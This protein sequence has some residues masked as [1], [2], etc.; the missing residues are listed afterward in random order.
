MRHEFESHS[1]FCDFQ[2]LFF[3]FSP[4]K[5][6]EHAFFY[7][8]HKNY[9]DQSIEQAL[10]E[11]WFDMAKQYLC[12]VRLSEQAKP[13][14]K[15]AEKVSIDMNH[16]ILF[17]KEEEGQHLFSNEEKFL[18]HHKRIYQ[19]C[20]NEGNYYIEVDDDVERLG[21]RFIDMIEVLGRCDI[22]EVTNLCLGLYEKLDEKRIREYLLHIKDM[23]NDQGFPKRCAANFIA[24]RRP[25]S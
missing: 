10:T 3:Y 22:D 16:M 7:G 21:E 15:L 20:F 24:S 4:K 17:G 6:L 14:Q 18:R 19:G 9:N 11:A 5:L 8:R 12:K 23:N 13:M 25:Q 1:D 2:N